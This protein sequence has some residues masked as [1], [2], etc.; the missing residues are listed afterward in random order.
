MKNNNLEVLKNH[1]PSMPKYERDVIIQ[2]LM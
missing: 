1:I 2:S